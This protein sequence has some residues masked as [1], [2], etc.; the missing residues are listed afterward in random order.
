[1][2][3]QKKFKWALLPVAAFATMI[4]FSAFVAGSETNIPG[5]THALCENGTSKVCKVRECT[6]DGCKYKVNECVTA[7]FW[8]T[9][10]CK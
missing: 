3:L 5:H 1:M 10:D 9:K 6:T 2:M 8:D 4:S 7:G